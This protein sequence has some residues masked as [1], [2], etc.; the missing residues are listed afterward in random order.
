MNILCRKNELGKLLNFMSQKFPEDFEFY[1]KTWVFPRDQ[2]HFENHLQ[3][4]KE[5]EEEDELLSISNNKAF[6]N[7]VKQEKTDAIFIV[8]PEMGCQG[9]GIFLIRDLNDLEKFIGGQNT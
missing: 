2:R 5:K 3:S 6:I 7:K 8:K 4:I 1:P 9:K